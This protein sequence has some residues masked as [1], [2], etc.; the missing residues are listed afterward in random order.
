MTMRQEYNKLIRDKIL[1]KIK[2]EDGL[3]CHIHIAN[4]QEFKEKLLE[5]L[6]EEVEEFKHDSRDAE[7]IDVAEVIEHIL[8]FYRLDEHLEIVPKKSSHKKFRKKQQEKVKTNGSFDQRIILE[9]TE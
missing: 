8:K 7:L 3:V 9:Y 2:R 1:D 5:K 4:E 6:E